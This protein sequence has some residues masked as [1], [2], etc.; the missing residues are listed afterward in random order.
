[1]LGLRGSVDGPSPCTQRPLRGGLAV[2]CIL[3]SSR[4]SGRSRVPL[5]E[6]GETRDLRRTNRY[7]LSYSSFGPSLL[8]SKGSPHPLVEGVV[9]DA[10]ASCGRAEAFCFQP[11]RFASRQRY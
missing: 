3:R 11:F 4:A 2:P 7:V 8:Q 9:G 6:E 5:P 1:M 10:K